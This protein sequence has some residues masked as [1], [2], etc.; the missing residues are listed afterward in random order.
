M[1]PC[2]KRLSSVCCKIKTRN[3]LNIIL[4]VFTKVEVSFGCIFKRLWHELKNIK[5]ELRKYIHLS[6]NVSDTLI[7]IA[8]SWWLNIYSCQNVNSRLDKVVSVKGIEWYTIISESQNGFRS[9]VQLHRE[10]INFSV[11][12]VIM[13]IN[14]KSLLFESSPCQLVHLTSDFSHFGH[15]A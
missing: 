6:V 10:E 14:W 12:I 13:K 11:L 8:F 3:I 5:C 1:I 4:K 9:T 2:T 15:T 7:L